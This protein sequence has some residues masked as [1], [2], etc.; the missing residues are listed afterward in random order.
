MIYRLSQKAITMKKQL[1]AALL[2]T[3]FS[4]AALAQTVATV[5]GTK[6]DSAEVDAQVQMLSRESQGQVQDSPELRQSIT[7]RLITRTLMIQEAKR[8]KIDQSPQ[9]KAALDEAMAEAKKLGKHVMVRH[10]RTVQFDGNPIT[11]NKISRKAD[12]T[13]ET[14]PVTWA[15]T[16]A[17]S[18]PSPAC[19]PSRPDDPW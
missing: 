17:T 19:A 6:I 13:F 2:I 8:L 4:G 1:L 15:W 10:N 16:P 3:A 7:K 14:T 5:N 18:S 12:G 11:G 9:Y